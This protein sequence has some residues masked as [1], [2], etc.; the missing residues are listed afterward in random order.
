MS[1]RVPPD[2][3]ECAE[4]SRRDVPWRLG[5]TAALVSVC[6][7][8]VPFEGLVFTPFD[9]IFGRN[10]K[11]VLQLIKNSWL[12]DDMPEKVR[13][14]DVIDCVLQLRDRIRS[15]SEIVNAKEEI[16]K[17]RSKVLYDRNTKPV[18]YKEGE[19]V[20]VLLPLIGK[21][22]QANFFGPYVIE[23]RIG[24]VDYAVRTPDRR[25]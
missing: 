10:I 1:G 17:K 18:S 22:L 12:K 2:A 16:A 4:G 3:K 7:H 5:S 19:L 20:L 13:S 8:E 25:K 6:L 24:E 9:I 15:S 23:R 14:K 11:G 21:P